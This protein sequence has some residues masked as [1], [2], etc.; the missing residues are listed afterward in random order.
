[1]DRRSWILFLVL[2]SLWGASY[3]FIK[4]G[5][6][7][8]SPAMVAFLRIA[9]AA[10]ILAPIAIRQDALRGL[11]GRAGAL[12]LV[13]AV[14]VAVP[15]WL[16][17]AGEQEISSALTG[18]LVSTAAIFTPLLAIWVDREERFTGLRLV[19][20]GV[21]FGGVVLLFGLDLSGS[22]LALLGG[23]AVVVAS[24]GYAIGGLLVKNRFAGTAPLGVVTSVMGWSAV[25]L[26]PAALLSAPSELPDAGPIAAVT[27]LGVLGTGIAFVIFYDLI[28]RV[29]PAKTMLVSYVAPGFAVVYGATLLGEEISVATIFGLILILVGSWLGA[30]GRLPP[31]AAAAPRDSAPPR[32]RDA[33]RRAS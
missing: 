16:I 4:I 15:F 3:L 10:L 7:E 20:V 25:M 1:M 32:A 8:M 19:G 14:Q 22:S 12:A 30:G 11:R 28:A 33:V 18:I 26:A 23:L 29:G 24:L 21:G 13:A 17:A 9:L 5:L 27:A 6:R 2:A 31:D